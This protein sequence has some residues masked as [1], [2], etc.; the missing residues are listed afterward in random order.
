ML[1]STKPNSLFSI[2]LC[3]LQ[4]TIIHLIFFKVSYSCKYI[5]HV[6]PT[7][8]QHKINKIHICRSHLENTWDSDG[9]PKEKTNEDLSCDVIQL[10][11]AWKKSTCNDAKMNRLVGRMD[12]V[13]IRRISTFFFAH[14]SNINQTFVFKVFEDLVS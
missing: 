11:I 4:R 12:G 5:R 14:E 9:K 8:T 6:H 13:E 10:E 2:I 1:E 3:E 7:N